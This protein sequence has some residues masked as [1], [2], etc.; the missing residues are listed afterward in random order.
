MQTQTQNQEIDVSLIIQSFQ[1]KIAQLTTEVVVKEA[2]IRH[3][4]NE[5]EKSKKELI[6]KKE[7]K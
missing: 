2:T 7:D 4:T 1:D 6:S 5:I 3:L